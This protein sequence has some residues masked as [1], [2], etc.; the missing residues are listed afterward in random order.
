MKKIVFLIGIA[1][2]SCTQKNMIITSNN[3]GMYHLNQQ[4]SSEIHKDNFEI[5]LDEESKIRS[6][7]TR[8]NLYK[9][10]EGFGVGT[11][12]LRIEKQSNTQRRELKISKESFQIGSLG[13]IVT[14]ND[15]SFVDENNDSKVDFIWIQR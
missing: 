10:T 2:F 15:V 9:T 7:I 5:T 1:I 6:I 11:N 4:I 14:Y 13:Q 3:I 12:L 8:S